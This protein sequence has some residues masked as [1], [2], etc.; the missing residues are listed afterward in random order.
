MK[1]LSILI[2]ILLVTSFTAYSQTNYENGFYINSSNEKIACLI[3]NK[4]WLNNPTEISLKYSEDEQPKTLTIESIKEFGIIGKSRYQRFNVDIDRSSK[5][6]SSLDHERNPVFKQEQ[7]FLKVLIEGKANL[8]SYKSGNIEV[9]FYNF[10][11]PDVEQLI[12]KSY[13]TNENQVATNNYFRQQIATN[14][15]CTDI[16]N[17]EIGNL[18]YEANELIDLFM[19]YNK[20][21]HSKFSNYTIKDKKE[22]FHLYLKTG[23]QN[24]SLEIKNS[25]SD[26]KNTDF[27]NKLGFRVGFEAEFILPFN[28]GKWA[29]II[30]PTYQNFKSKKE[31]TALTSEVDYKSIEVPFGVKH[32]MF[33]NKKSSLFIDGLIIMD[34]SLNSKFDFKR[35]FK[36]DLDI[37]SGSNIALGFGYNYDRKFSVE[38]RYHSSRDLLTNYQSWDSEY[39]TVS[40]LFGYTIF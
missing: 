12:S 32:Y 13:L 29:F 24:S 17:K 33:L 38:L 28:N 5:L 8:Y 11:Q 20:C 14:L 2:T 16:S 30:E 26:T 22:V 10:D 23:I 36:S 19:K 18:E 40:L 15:K 1:H 39:K 34:L 3:L 6:L 35:E 21:V 31:T 25:E 4:D 7:L 27:G 37:E 9:F